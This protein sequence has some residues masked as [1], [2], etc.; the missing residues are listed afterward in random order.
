[1]TVSEAAKWADLIIM[2]APDAIYAE[3]IEAKLAFARGF[4]VRLAASTRPRA[5]TSS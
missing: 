1:M 5:S 3:S 2:L 4:D